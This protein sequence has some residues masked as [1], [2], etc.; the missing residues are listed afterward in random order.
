M[1]GAEYEVKELQVR[2][3][4]LEALF[5]ALRRAHVRHIEDY[6]HH[7]PSCML[8]RPD[9]LRAPPNGREFAL[10]KTQRVFLWHP[11]SCY[12]LSKHH[13]HNLGRP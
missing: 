12:P 6:E 10:K 1:A 3:V 9:Y 11:S 8:H 5:R 7:I 4:A 2:K 13:T